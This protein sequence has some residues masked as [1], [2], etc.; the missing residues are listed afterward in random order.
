MLRTILHRLRFALPATGAAALV[1]VAVGGA[2]NGGNFILG[3]ANTATATTLLSG[4][5]GAN[6]LLRVTGSGTAASIR[7]DAGSGIA[8]NGISTSGTGQS[9]Q[10]TSG[11]GLSGF[12]IG[13]TGSSSGVYGQTASTD[14]G[15]AGV[16]GRNTAG[17][18]GLQAIVSG[19]N[20]VPP[21]KINSSARVASL[22]A[23][24]LDGLDSTGLPYWKLGGN[25]G[26]IPGAN[27]LGT[28]D[29][30][31][32]ELRVNGQRALRLEPDA[33]SPNL[34]GGFSGNLAFTGIG[35]FGMTIAGGGASGNVNV[36]SDS[37]GTVG[38]GWANAAGNL[39][40]T[41]NN[42]EFATV[43]GGW[44]NIASNFSSTIVGGG[45]N[46][47]SGFYSTVGGGYG[48]TASHDVSFAAGAQAKANQ[49]GA[50][51]W[52][53]ST[54]L[55]IA[56]A[57]LISPAANTFTVRA[58]G[59][60]WLGTSGFT[61]TIYANHF[62]DTSAGAAPG[63]N[64]AG[65]Y[66]SSA[67]M[68][69]DASDRALKHEFRPLNKG[70]VLEK[71]ARMPITSWSYKSEKPSVRHIGPMAQDFYSAFGLGLDNKHI[72]TIDEGG[73]ALAA[74][75]GLYRENQQLE[76]T[77]RMLT[78]RLTSQNARLTKL[79]REVAKLSR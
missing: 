37:F 64:I 36:V 74:I 51:V 26:T 13:T 21:L 75:Q 55:G 17:G 7:A 3:Q 56:N 14:P 41:P 59:G 60:I 12:H 8:I 66:L 11:Y 65:A 50:F 68:W 43:A 31:A 30:K 47:A 67:G 54:S 19:T 44:Q 1:L 5:P 38:G 78:S 72:G 18:P 52:A 22:N 77:N 32:L 34:I 63:M 49:P 70:S 45:H 16:T 57:D 2:A 53:D 15:S 10:S 40:G 61:P 29:N 73:V 46:T 48:N 6:P 27:F 79:E 24:L 76:R 39:D 69:T 58:T 28:T 25:A 35:A 71:V 20:T 4:N 9:G 23:D 42:A 33:T 62:I